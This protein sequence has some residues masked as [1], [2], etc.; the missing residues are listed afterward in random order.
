[1]QYI[2]INPSVSNA[3]R[4]LFITDVHVV[5]TITERNA[6][7]VQEGDICK[8]TGDKTYI[9]DGVNWLTLN[10][11]N[12]NVTSVNN[13]NPV[14]GNISLHI[15]EL[16]NCLSIERLNITI[17]AGGSVNM[18]DWFIN[19]SNI[20]N[21][22]I[23]NGNNINPFFWGTRGD[24]DYGQWKIQ[25][26]DGQ[27]QTINRLNI[28]LAAEFIIFQF[29]RSLIANIMDDNLNDGTVR[30]RPLGINHDQQGGTAQIINTT[31]NN[32]GRFRTLTAGTN[33]TITQN[34][35]TITIN[36]TAAGGASNLSDLND[37]VITNPATDDILIYNGANYIN[38]QRFKT[39]ETTITNHGTRITNIENTTIWQATN[40]NPTTNYTLIH[41]QTNQPIIV[42]N[43]D[44]AQAA[45]NTVD[46]LSNLYVNSTNMPT[47]N[48]TRGA[49]TPPTATQQEGLRNIV[50]GNTVSVPQYLPTNANVQYYGND[51]GV[52][53]VSILRIR[54]DVGITGN[55]QFCSQRYTNSSNNYTVYGLTSNNAAIIQNFMAGAYDANLQINS[56][57]S[58]NILQ[59]G[60]YVYGYVTEFRGEVINLNANTIYAFAISFSGSPGGGGQYRTYSRLFISQSQN[61]TQNQ[62]YPNDF[63][64]TNNNGVLTLSDVSIKTNERW[65]VNNNALINNYLCENV[66][67]VIR[68]TN[69]LFL[70]NTE[71]NDTLIKVN[72]AQNVFRVTNSTA[73]S[74]WANFGATRSSFIGDVM[75]GVNGTVLHQDKLLAS[76]ASY[77]IKNGL[78]NQTWASFSNTDL[79]ISGNFTIGANSKIIYANNR[80][81][82][83]Y[84]NDGV[85]PAYVLTLT[86]INEWYPIAP[87]ANVTLENSIGFQ[88]V[89][90]ASLQCTAGGLYKVNVTICCNYTDN[91]EIFIRAGRDANAPPNNLYNGSYC[92][93]N[94]FGNYHTLSMC[95]IA[96]IATNEYVNLFA[97]APAGIGNNDL[98]IIAYTITCENLLVS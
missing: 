29:I 8:V 53:V 84:F 46:N 85:N 18:L 40:Y 55:I 77:A 59:L 81:C 31:V 88:K 41:S 6:L 32:L 48:G 90:T 68:G 42:S 24:A 33:I 75:V 15:N 44:D 11:N 22:M 10:D 14:N 13:I 50:F 12:G 62:T 39:A 58:A 20:F 65:T 37:V 91:N 35:N 60:N 64:L 79:T 43:Y 74:L 95:F 45:I 2:P 34:D 23:S 51:Y 86:N 70:S 78:D 76:G 9:Y 56:G 96:N 69:S 1:M 63:T 61:V 98:S 38:T 25:N 92:I 28:V 66:F 7:V 73:T 17:P 97:R 47:F 87:A 71:I 93:A 67:K 27:Q 49:N 5:N 26:N 52:N 4:D 54:Y 80:R 89:G 72:N 94:C 16:L 3:D 82:Q 83:L 57:N 30:I 19:D 21:E 36:S